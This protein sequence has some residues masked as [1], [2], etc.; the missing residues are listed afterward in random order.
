MTNFSPICYEILLMAQELILYPEIR[1]LSQSRR[2]PHQPFGWTDET[3]GWSNQLAG[4]KRKASF[5][6][7]RGEILSSSWPWFKVQ[8]A[9]ERCSKHGQRKT[10]C[11]TM[12]G[13][14]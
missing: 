10:H 6:F 8:S 14:C 4:M 1:L 9:Q 13:R 5:F 12:I 11:Q 2:S 7:G 3:K